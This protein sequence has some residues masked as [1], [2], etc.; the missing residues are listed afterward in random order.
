LTNTN[1]F[2]TNMKYISNSLQKLYAASF[3]I[4]PPYPNLT[5]KFAI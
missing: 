2:V 1:E 3:K 5:V 4:F